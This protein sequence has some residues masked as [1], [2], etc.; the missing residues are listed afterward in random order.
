MGVDQSNSAG[1]I[2]NP[3]NAQHR[4]KNLIL[5]DRH[6]WGDVIEQCRPNK[7]A[8][9]VSFHIQAP[10]IDQQLRAFGHALLDIVFDFRLMLSSDN[11]PHFTGL[12]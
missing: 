1:K 7:K 11:R 6:L 9:V 3:N 10:A 4:A 5:V 8:L 12:V 2:W